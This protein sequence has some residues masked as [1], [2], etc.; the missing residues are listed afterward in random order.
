MIKKISRE[1][2]IDHIKNLK[3]NNPR[4]FLKQIKFVKERYEA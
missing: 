4:L 2:L 1:K 3:K